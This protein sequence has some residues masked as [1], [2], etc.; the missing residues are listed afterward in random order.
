MQVCRTGCKEAGRFVVDLVGDWAGR[1]IDSRAMS[2]ITNSPWIALTLGDPAGIGPEIAIAAM[3]REDVRAAANLLV[4]GPGE[5]LPSELE[6]VTSLSAE[7]PP[8]AG[9]VRAFETAGATDTWVP[10]QVQESAG[11]AALAA[12]RAGHELALRGSVDA[13]VTGPVSKQ[14]MHLAGEA[15]EGQTEL[16]GRWC[17]ARRFQMTVRF[18]GLTVMLLTR[19]MPL[20]TALA[21]ITTERVFDHLRM[22]DETLR[23]NGLA[24]PRIALA[25]LNPHAGE[26]GLLGSEEI[27]I[28]EPAM[29]LAR[30]ERIEVHGPVSPDTLFARALKGEFDGVLSLY[31][32]QAF[33]P[34]KLLGQDTGVTVIAGLPYLRVSPIHG[35]A[36]DLVGTGRASE[37]N[38]VAAL[39]EAA[40][41]APAW[42]CDTEQR[43]VNQS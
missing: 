19:H 22:L 3:R 10:G 20:T 33:I 4:V 29:M 28:L 26:A 25:G 43:V 11:A 13:L 31:H 5:L 39:L 21:E 30:D 1:A 9:Q 32:D 12:L 18:Q 42:T 7:L 41:L 37:R 16:L 2:A 38:L 6:R 14:A 23:R 34:M 27:E 17:D 15:C 35:T 40:E 36:F 8:G 24:R